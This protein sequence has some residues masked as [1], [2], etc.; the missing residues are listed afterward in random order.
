MSGEANFEL[1]AEDNVDGMRTHSGR[2]AGWLALLSF[3]IGNF[4]AAIDIYNHVPPIGDPTLWAIY[5]LC[6]F[7]ILWEFVVRD[8][9]IRRQFRQAQAMNSPA[10]MRWD[11][12]SLSIDTDLGQARFEW[13][14]FYRWRVSKT[15]L[16]LYRDAGFLFV[17]PRRAVG[18]QGIDEM[19]A[20]LKAAGVKER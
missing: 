15:S 12:K 19:V 20:A 14:Q 13:P 16:L 2:L 9:T 1:T 17:V 11:D 4:Y 8:A 18:D 6:M 10:R 5:L 3:G 7:L